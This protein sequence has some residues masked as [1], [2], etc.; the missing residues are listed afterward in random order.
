MKFARWVF[1]V[2][3]IYGPLSLTRRSF[4]GSSA[5]RWLVRCS[6]FFPAR[7]P[8]RYRPMMLPSILEKIS[9][10]IALILLHQQQRIPSSSFRIGM[11][12]LIFAVLFTISFIRTRGLLCASKPAT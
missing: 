11:V 8:V 10:G 6:S 12:D 2:A 7:D 9:Y 3:G 5:R 4:T 1:L